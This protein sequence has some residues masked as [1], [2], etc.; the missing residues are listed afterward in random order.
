M[1][2]RIMRFAFDGEIRSSISVN[3]DI[4]QGSP[5]SFIIFLIYIY[6]IFEPFKRWPDITALSFINDVGII[7]K[8]FSTEANDRRLQK[9]LKILNEVASK[10]QIEFNT[11][12]TKFIHFY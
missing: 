6:H 11:D 1:S 7:T 3:S 10:S 2:D 5:V 12:K 8:S 4:P 9:I